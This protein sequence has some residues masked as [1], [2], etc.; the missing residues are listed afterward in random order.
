MLEEIHLIFW[1]RVQ[2]VG[3]RAIIARYA[4]KYGLKGTVKNLENGTVEVFGAGKR[5][6]LESF[7]KAIKDHKGVLSIEKIEME[8]SPLKKEYPDFHIIS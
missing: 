1:G 5:S 4:E 2:G 6:A 3:F 8:Y 7:V